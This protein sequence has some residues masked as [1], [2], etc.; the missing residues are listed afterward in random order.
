MMKLFW[1]LLA[2]WQLRERGATTTEYALVL[3]LV[4]VVL[5]TTLQS[6]GSVLNSKLNTIISSISGA[7]P[8]Q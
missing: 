8:T 1:R 4:V 6:L 5:I 7:G 3:A 2:Q